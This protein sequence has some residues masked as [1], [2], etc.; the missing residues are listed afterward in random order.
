[1]TASRKCDLHVQKLSTGCG[2]SRKK[3]SRMQ[4]FHKKRSGNVGSGAP[5]PEPAFNFCCTSETDDR[6]MFG[7]TQIVTRYFWMRLATIGSNLGIKFLITLKFSIHYFFKTRLLLKM[8]DPEFPY[9]HPYLEPFCLPAKMVAET[10][11]RS[12]QEIS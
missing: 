4:D 6:E 7:K 5:L 11:T 2:I 12:L 8:F 9:K 1:M 3:E 10:V